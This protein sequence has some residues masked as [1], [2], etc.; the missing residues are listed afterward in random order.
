MN[1]ID[2]GENYLII[3]F[4]EVFFILNLKERSV[5][6]NIEPCGLNSPYIESLSSYIGRLANLHYVTTGI[7]VSKVFTP[8]LNTTYLVNTAKKGGDGFFKSSSGINGTGKMAKDFINTLEHLTS[9][10]DL[11]DT[12]LIKLNELIPV[13]GMYRNKKAWCPDCFNDMFQ[14]GQVYEPLIWG[15]SFYKVCLTHKKPLRDYCPNCGSYLNFLS[16][17][18]VPGYCSKCLIWLGDNAIIE[19]LDMEYDIKLSSFI[20][21]LLE[22]SLSDQLLEYKRKDIASS[23][24]RIVNIVF[25]NNISTA[26]SY[27]GFSYA[28]FKGWYSGINRPTVVALAEICFKL[29]ISLEV[30]LKLPDNVIGR[31]SDLDNYASKKDKPYRK[32]YDYIKIKEILDKII[33]KE[34]IISIT[35]ISHLIGCDRRHLS[36]CFP[37]ECAKIISNNKKNIKVQK[38]I[39]IAEITKSV[40]AAFFLL[41]YNNELPSYRKMECMLGPNVLREQAFREKFEEL[42]SLY[43]LIY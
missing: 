31:V 23:L 19:D 15:F 9:R 16:R 25:K 29:N 36:R 5:L 4:K 11:S 20:K 6:Y 30:F 40:E 33:E 26:A 21:E 32:K 3:F 39:R 7:L 13:R 38:E 41:L 37:N 34:T 22:L 12:T 14:I 27:L 24:R 1:R 35:K 42:R 18:S 28:T 10:T 43:R 17:K 8:F 2:L